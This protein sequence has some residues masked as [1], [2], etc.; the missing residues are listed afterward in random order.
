MKRTLQCSVHKHEASSDFL[1]PRAGSDQLGPGYVLHEFQLSS[2]LNDLGTSLPKFRQYG[3]VLFRNFDPID[4]WGPY[5]VIQQIGLDNKVDIALIAETMDPV[6]TEPL[7]PAMNRHNS[8]IWPLLP[9]THTFL[10]F[11]LFHHEE[12][13][14]MV[15]MADRPTGYDDTWVDFCRPF[16]QTCGSLVCICNIG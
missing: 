15:G 1:F 14:G 12:L 9:P 3:F 11:P 4:V 10:G 2:L 13:I 6:K 7:S 5:E 8:S 16:F